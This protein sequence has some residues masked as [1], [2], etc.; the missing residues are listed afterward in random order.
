VIARRCC[1]ENKHCDMPRNL[2]NCRPPVP[3]QVPV[4]VNVKNPIAAMKR[5]LSEGSAW[6]LSKLLIRGCTLDMILDENRTTPLMYVVSMGK[7]NEGQ[8]NC[9]R[10][11]LSQG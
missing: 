5:A 4:V 1:L 6:A 9:V 2:E 11:L 8:N 7:L 10:F 3:T